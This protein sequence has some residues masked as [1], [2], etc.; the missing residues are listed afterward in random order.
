MRKNNSTD[1]YCGKRLE[2]V[3][4]SLSWYRRKDPRTPLGM[5]YLYSELQ[6]RF[7]ENN[8]VEV[9]F[10]EIDVRD[11]ISNV[12]HETLIRNPEILGIGV[13]AWNA[14]HTKKII[15][16]LRSLE[17]SGIIV[18]GGPEIT[19]GG[20]ELNEEFPE[21]QYF[22]KGFGEKAFVGI[23]ESIKSRKEIAIKGVYRKGEKIGDLLA[24][25]SLGFDSSPFSREE[26]IPRITGDNFI[27][28][29]T[30]RGCVYRC[31]FC[32]FRLPNGT[33][34]E[35]N[36]E[37]VRK[38]LEIIKKIGVKNVAVLDPVFF[39]NRERAL[40]ILDLI[41]EITPDIKF[42]IQTRF[43]HL[44]LEIIEKV[45][46]L[47]IVLESGLQTLDTKVQKRIKRINNREKVISVIHD[48]QV[49]KI[50]FETHLIYGLPEQT[51]ES[52]IYDLK[53]LM[54]KECR[55]LRIFPLSRLRGT[56]IDLESNNSDIIFSP[57]FP[58][59]VIETKWMN[60][61]EVFRLKKLQA[62]IEDNNGLISED[63]MKVF[64]SSME[65]I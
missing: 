22:V 1:D 20:N 9:Y 10:E 16:S 48:I 55:V 54:E 46:R 26:L 49:H 27:R 41:E 4:L 37:T 38:E 35:S 36:L 30:Q 57:I 43:E 60:R 25:P 32:A 40:N 45:S 61:D 56:E 23:V 19:Y 52:F 39:L 28:W 12:I 8:E 2:V 17:Y 5:A 11:N 3:L 62:F 21:V 50:M 44:N 63:L 29:Q 31:S 13:Y 34:A 47:N 33:M 15:T 58:E 14:E 53:V 64:C 7:S 6:N 65:V 51:Y 24:D 59:E 18:L 42:S